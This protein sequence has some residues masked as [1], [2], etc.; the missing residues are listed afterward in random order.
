MNCIIQE[1][2]ES[3]GLGHDIIVKLQL[4]W[5]SLTLISKLFLLCI[6]LNNKRGWSGWKKQVT[7]FLCLKH[8]EI[9]LEFI[10]TSHT[11]TH[12]APAR[13]NALHVALNVLLRSLNESPYTKSSTFKGGYHLLCI[14]IPGVIP[15]SPNMSSSNFRSRDYTYGFWFLLFCFSDIDVLYFAI[16]I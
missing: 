4:G 11:H 9:Y 7:D 1:S 3:H 15:S 5:I 8:F 10:S 14:S 13:L 6:T 16:R 12:F 2:Y